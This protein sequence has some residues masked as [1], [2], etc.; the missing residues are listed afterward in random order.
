[1]THTAMQQR[2]SPLT[3]WLTARSRT[4]IIPQHTNTHTQKTCD[5]VVLSLL[6]NTLKLSIGHKLRLAQNQTVCC[7]APTAPCLHCAM[8]RKKNRGYDPRWVK[9]RIV[10]EGRR[11]GGVRDDR[12]SCGWMNCSSGHLEIAPLAFVSLSFPIR[13]K[14]NTTYPDQLKMSWRDPEL[15]SVT[16]LTNTVYVSWEWQWMVTV[17]LLPVTGTVQWLWHNVLRL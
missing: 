16:V 11:E 9:W 1:M 5:T 13:Q 12:W 14:R 15:A 2:M 6:S 3:K 17:L 4:R 8:A 10:R 7:S